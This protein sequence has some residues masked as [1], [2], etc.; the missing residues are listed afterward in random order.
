[1]STVA[2]VG[3]SAQIFLKNHCSYPI[4]PQTATLLSTPFS[5][6]EVKSAAGAAGTVCGK[7]EFLNVGF[8]LGK[9]FRFPTRQE[10]SKIHLKM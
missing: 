1:M 6:L 10:T 5:P 8:T 7:I 3:T 9:H 2:P 4:F